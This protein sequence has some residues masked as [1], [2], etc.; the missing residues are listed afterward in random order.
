MKVLGMIYKFIVKTQTARAARM[1]EQ[2]GRHMRINY[3]I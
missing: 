3:M 1:I 2:H